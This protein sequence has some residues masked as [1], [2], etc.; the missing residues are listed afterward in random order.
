MGIEPSTVAV[1][2]GLELST[3]LTGGGRN[4]VYLAGRGGQRLVVRGTGRSAQSLDWEL[5]L[6][7]HLAAQG[8]GVPRTVPTDDGRRHVG[9]IMV[10]E[11]VDGAPPRTDSDWRRV[12][13]TVRAVHRLTEG[14][15]Q[16]PGFAS[17]R[18]LL[19]AERG[20]DVG[21]D[22][23]PPDAVRLV[24]EA[25]RPVLVGPECAVHGDLDGSNVLITERTVT[26]L[27][28]DESRVDVPWFDLA[29]VPPV[30]VTDLPVPLDA[31]AYAG[32]AW[33]TATC[34]LP[35]P[36]YARRRLTQL[37]AASGDGRNGGQGEPG[38][39]Q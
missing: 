11:F 27:D 25:W 31:V 26:L 35:E 4:P 33:E 2:E 32:L 13:D 38:R 36:D 12:V 18:D 9:G 6:L 10:Q 21:L 39:E 3:P 16:R 37:Y 14:W 34:W 23:M 19:T 5:D 29:F 30:A 20:G 28:W 24:R 15:P 7:E 8:I 17:A 1:W 22:A